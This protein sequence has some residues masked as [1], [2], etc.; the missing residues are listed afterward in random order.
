MTCL[1]RLAKRKAPT[2]FS[3]AYIEGNDSHCNGVL[4][5]PTLSPAALHFLCLKSV[6]VTAYTLILGGSGELGQFLVKCQKCGTLYPSGILADFETL[7]RNPSSLNDVTT[8]CSSCGHQN[9]SKP[10]NMV[11]TLL[12]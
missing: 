12:T 8:K 10:R 9:I 5:T 1:N 4:C 11:Y 6:R 7:Q 3:G 2:D